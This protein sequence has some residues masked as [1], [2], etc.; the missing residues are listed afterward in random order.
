MSGAHNAENAV[1]ALLA[2]RH[3]GVDPADALAAIGS[4]RGV[5][6]RLT[7]LGDFAGVQLYDD[8][9][10]H[11]TAIRRTI[12]FQRLLDAAARL[13]IHGSRG[14]PG[15][16]LGTAALGVAKSVENMGGSPR[17]WTS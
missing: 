8:F 13:V 7:R 16:I 11:P 6:R 10:H 9:A 14:L 15:W 17:V 12:A 3:A 2:A 5:R 4:F 1:A